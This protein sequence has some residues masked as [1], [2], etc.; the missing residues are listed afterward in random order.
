MWDVIKSVPTG[1]I[2]DAL[3]AFSNKEEKLKIKSLHFLLKSYKIKTK[4][5]LNLKYKEG[6]NNIKTNIK[7]IENKDIRTIKTTE[8]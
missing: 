3:S 7:E 8:K 5:K 4:R 2:N 6:K 1:K